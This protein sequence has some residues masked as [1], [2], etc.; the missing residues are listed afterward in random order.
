VAFSGNTLVVEPPESVAALSPEL[1]QYLRQLNQILH[2]NYERQEAGAATFPASRLLQRYASQQYPLGSEGRFVHEDFG[3]LRGVFVRFANE[4]TESATPVGWDSSQFGHGFVTTVFA[5]S[6]SALFVGLDLTQ[7]PGEYG[8][9]LSHG[10]V[11][12][13]LTV[14]GDAA[15]RFLEWTESGLELTVMSTEIVVI[16]DFVES[17]VPAGT[18]ILKHTTAAN[19]TAGVEEDIASLLSQIATINGNV[20]TLNENFSGV[21]PLTDQVL[22]IQ[23]KL[24]RVSQ[25]VT[26]T[27]KLLAEFN[28]DSVLV[29]AQQTLAVTRSYY[30]L[31]RGISE[32][33]DGMLTQ[34]VLTA[35]AALD[36]KQQAKSWSDAAGIHAE[37][38]S[39]RAGYASLQA[40]DSELSAQA[41]FSY[42]E[43]ALVYRDEA[44]GYS[45]SASASST[46]AAGYANDADV[47][48]NASIAAR[49]LTLVYRDAAGGYAATASTEATLAASYRNG[50]GNWAPNSSF[51]TG[52]T[53]D[54]NIEGWTD[55][56]ALMG[57]VSHS[58]DLGGAGFYPVGEH[59]LGIFQ[60]ASSGT[61]TNYAEY[62]SDK[63]A[64]MP[65]SY[66]QYYALVASSR[67]NLLVQA[68]FYN[69]AGSFVGSDSV[70][71]N[72]VADNASPDLTSW[73]Q[74]GKKAIQAPATATQMSL[75]LRKYDTLSGVN[76]FG[77]FLR[78][79]V[80]PA[81]SG[82]TTW[83]P[84]T[85]SAGTVGFQAVSARLS[86]EETVR[87][88]ADSAISST[89]TTLSTTV[90]GHTATL[91]TYGTSI[92]G[93]NAKYGISVDVNG[94]V[95][96]YELNGTGTGGEML[97]RVDKFK[98]AKPG[99]GTS[100]IFD[101]DST[102]LKLA[103]PL[104][105]GAQSLIGEA[106][107]FRLR[108]GAGF[109]V[110]SNCILWFGPT[111]VALNAETRTN[112]VFAMG[113]DGI[114]YYG[115]TQL[116]SNA[117]AGLNAFS[118]NGN[119]GFASAGEV[120][121]E[122]PIPVQPGTITVTG[123]G[124]A[125]GSGSVG[126]GFLIYL[127]KPG[128]SHVA[129]QSGTISTTDGTTGFSI[130]YTGSTGLSGNEVWYLCLE[131]L[132][133]AAAPA[134][135]QFVEV[136]A[137]GLVSQ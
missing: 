16:G 11:P 72:Y 28:P 33:V 137:D 79:Y 55:F 110:S 92:G 131:L 96:G 71:Y 136:S 100:S 15:G 62:A 109:G 13:N 19:G 99:V 104:Y 126:G 84:Y 5:H 25:S 57:G 34:V 101:L 134:P 32:S 43:T 49:D 38:S 75:F 48:A 94:Y 103:V 76:S 88:N 26:I 98:I 90:G 119:V 45:A 78:P 1:H 22:T 66:I 93:L 111:S 128:G 70:T 122:V 127:R 60:G 106:S 121:A 69:T 2:E 105:Y 123:S 21:I 113:T 77:W 73:I 6:D 7:G 67:A 58:R 4:A 47:S 8:W 81:L 40:G 107:G 56:G 97:F 82:Q 46:L 14:S 59:V 23:Q 68:V 64:V 85:A 24:A 63:F 89:V 112:G 35:N 53:N 27:N 124:T 135:D 86:T 52:G 39:E 102:G 83:N 87:A 117:G 61:P 120:V 129:L 132:R 9:V 10:I 95:T 51:A 12:A 29:E 108:H 37:V 125:T 115:A 18:V 118:V 31:T 41:S 30:S 50:V 65:S 114:I 80:G 74:I 130:S 91:T 42:K 133:N 44:G 17:T 54:S 3:V 20:A 36:S 116:S